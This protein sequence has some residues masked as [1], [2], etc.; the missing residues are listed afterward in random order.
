M[1][2]GINRF[3]GLSIALT[4]INAQYKSIDHLT[5]LQAWV[6]SGA[7]ATTT[8]PRATAYCFTPSSRAGR[9]GTGPVCGARPPEGSGAEC[10]RAAIW[11]AS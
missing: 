2:R 4:E 6:D 11:T 5:D 8:P 10:T 3:K 7:P 9:W 1:T